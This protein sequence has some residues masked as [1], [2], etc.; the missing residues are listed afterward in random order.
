[1]L[2]LLTVKLI[3]IQLDMY[4]FDCKQKKHVHQN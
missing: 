2:F 4:Q 1:M 3:H